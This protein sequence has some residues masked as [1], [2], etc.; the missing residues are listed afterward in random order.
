MS[1][2]FFQTLT[3]CGDLRA[4]RELRSQCARN[5]TECGAPS[6]QPAQY[7]VLSRSY[8]QYVLQFFCGVHCVA[9]PLP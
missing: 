6:G 8:R 4:L 1:Y 3:D 7:R 5:L 2:E 9:L